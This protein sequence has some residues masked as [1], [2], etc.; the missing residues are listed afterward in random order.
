M[1]RLSRLVSS[2]P[3][4]RYPITGTDDPCARAANGHA[5]ALPSPAMN[6]RRRIYEP[7]RRFNEPIAIEGAWEPGSL[8]GGQAFAAPHESAAGP[9]LSCSPARRSRTL[10]VEKRPKPLG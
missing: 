9:R 1:A 6:S 3:L 4:L 2:E 5:A 10:L 8:K 7:P